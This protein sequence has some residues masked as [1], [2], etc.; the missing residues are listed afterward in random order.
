[1][2][3]SIGIPREIK[4][5]EGRVALLPGACAELAHHGHEVLVERGAGRLSGYEDPAYAAAGARLVE[6]AEALYAESRLIVKVKE[7]VGPELGYLR[8]DHT[9]FCFLHLAANRELALALKSLGL[10]AIAFETLEVD[11][12]L[13]ILRPMS[14]VAGRVAVQVGTHLLHAPQ[15]GC[16]VLLGGVTGTDRGTVVV[17]GAGVAGSA[18]AAM[19]AAMGATVTVYD[20]NPDRLAAMRALG[21]NVTAL[22]ATREDMATSLGAADLLVGAVLVPGRRA[23]VV[24]QRETV[25]AMR[26]G[27][28]IVDISVDQ[29]GCVE[30]TRPVTYEAPTYVEEAVIH[31]TVTNMP[32]AVPRTASQALS[33]NVLP[34]VLRLVAPDWEADPALVAGINVRAGRFVNPSVRAEFE[35]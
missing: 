14:E 26:D 6:G 5:L 2:I 17:I 22:H 15:G 20:K 34:Y 9:L 24:V 35:D 32:G 16:G 10:T 3:M 30:T 19:A 8:A 31:F 7:P 27:S 29:G 21:P 25:A 18:A 1:M 28:V 23:P 12:R 4:P 11:G 33:A 13:P